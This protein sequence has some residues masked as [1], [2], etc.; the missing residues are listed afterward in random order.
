M[1]NK[2]CFKAPVIHFL[3]IL[4]PS[5]NSSIQKWKFGHYVLTIMSLRTNWYF[6]AEHKMI[7]ALCHTMA[8]HEVTIA[9]KLKKTFEKSIRLQACF[10]VIERPLK[11]S[12][13]EH[14]SYRLPLWSW[15]EK[16]SMKKKKSSSLWEIKGAQMS[17]WLWS[18]LFPFLWHQDHFIIIILYYI[19]LYYYIISLLLI[20]IV[21]QVQK[22][23]IEY[24]IIFSIS[25][26]IVLISK[27]FWYY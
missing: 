17:F 27:F 5:R 12:N 7:F 2:A 21:A 13:T 19:W 15:S 25:L 24:F 22:N 11:T 18:G 1:F 14:E 6:S 10:N 26:F 9:V 4:C 8:V 23:V 16:T 20:I 3:H